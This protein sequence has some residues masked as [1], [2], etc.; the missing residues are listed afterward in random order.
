MDF[1]QRTPRSA[2]AKSEKL[3]PECLVH[4]SSSSRRKRVKVGALPTW[5][6]ESLSQP[7]SHCWHAVTLY[8]SHFKANNLTCMSVDCGR[9]LK[10]PEKKMQKTQKK[11]KRPVSRVSPRTFLLWG[12]SSNHCTAVPLILSLLCQIFFP[13]VKLFTHILALKIMKQK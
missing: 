8:H 9:K 13:G 6:S 12:D 3:P 11:K 2:S 5:I 1:N 7:V 10:F 4:C